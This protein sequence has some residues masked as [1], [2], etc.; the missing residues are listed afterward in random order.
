MIGGVKR[1]DIITVSTKRNTGKYLVATQDQDLRR[2]LAHI[3]GIPLI[4]LNKVTLILESPSQS[5]YEYNKE[6]R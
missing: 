4:Y 6:V 5:S 1:D 2:T 3:P